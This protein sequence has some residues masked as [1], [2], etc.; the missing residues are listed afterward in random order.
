MKISRIAFK[1]VKRCK[2]LRKFQVMSEV[3]GG[4]IFME[5]Q[6]LRAVFIEKHRV[7]L[8]VHF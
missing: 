6:H 3:D 4:N 7:K 5:F 2:I 8:S 1:T